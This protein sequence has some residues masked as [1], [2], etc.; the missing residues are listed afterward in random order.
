MPTN[1]QR[2]EAA[3][4]KL[5]RQLEHRAQRARKRKQLTIAGSVLALVLLVAAGAL[6]YTV[7][8]G[9]DDS[10]QASD[11][12][13]TSADAPPQGAPLPKGRKTPLADTVSCAYPPSP[14]PAAK[15]VSPPR[16]DGIQT[17]VDKVSVSIE[18]TQGNIGLTLNNAESPCTVNSFVS[19]ASQGYFDNT[20]C[21]RLTTGEGLKVLQCGD[22]AGT[23]AGGPGYQFANEFPTDQFGPNDAGAQTP[24]IYPRGTIAMANAGPG[25][26]GSQFFLVY[27]DSTLPP[28][29][30]VFGTVDETGLKT[31][32][33]IAAGGI[34]GDTGMGDGKPKL[35]V[36]L[37]SVRMD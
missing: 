26:N 33:K 30:T 11:A 29:Y 4:R 6:V 5:E 37:T 25:T 17:T 2:R 27:A 36:Q 12:S 23:G 1:E 24:A 13:T 31:L 16:T 22:P 3:K 19:L 20:P 18:S 35:P 10:N 14:Q 15:P 34:D 8:K 28:Q 21:H 32:D 7:T 9:D